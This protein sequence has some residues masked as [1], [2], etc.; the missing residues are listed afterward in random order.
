MAPT[1]THKFV[2]AKGDS[3]DSTL[4][5]PSNWNDS[6]DI[7]TSTTDVLLGRQAA[8]AGDVEEIT[9]TSFG[10]SLIA[11]VDAAATRTLIGLDTLLK[12]LAFKD[13]IDDPTLINDKMVTLAKMAD[14]A[15]KSVIGRKT[16]AT[17][18]PEVI[19]VSDILDFLTGSAQGKIPVRGASAWSAQTPLISAEF[20]SSQVVLS[21]GQNDTQAHGLGTTPKIIVPYLKC[22]ASELG[23]TTGEFLPAY[24]V[25][26]SGGQSV[27]AASADDTNVYI[28]VR[29]TTGGFAIG[30]RPSGVFTGIDTSKWRIIVKA[31]A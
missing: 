6:H 2:S 14:M 24:S 4:V 26:N 13:T 10:R 20:V 8:G 27:I 11:A 18:V 9:C 16:A 3:P 15:T 12:A 7:K 23:Y 30:R 19:T 21:S 22:I 5:Q 31:Y 28:Q 1:V 25:F 29:D 17:G